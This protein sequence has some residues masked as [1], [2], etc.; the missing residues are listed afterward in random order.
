[1]RGLKKHLMLMLLLAVAMSLVSLP[2]ARAGFSDRETSRCGMGAGTWEPVPAAKICGLCPDWGL[3]GACRWPVFIYGK[4]FRE[5]AAAS[6]AKGGLSLP[7][8]KTW[9]LCSSAIYAVFDLRGAAEGAYDLR[10]DFSD[11]GKAVLYGG[12]RVVRWGNCSFNPTSSGADGG[13]SP[14][15]SQGGSGLGTEAWAKLTD[16]GSPGLLKLVAG[17]GSGAGITRAYAVAPGM[18]LEGA[19]A[20]NG[21]GRLEVRFDLRG[22][23]RMRYDVVFL[24]AENQPL[25]LEGFIT[26]ADILP[27][28]P[29]PAPAAQPGI[30]G[31]SGETS[32]A[33][34]AGRPPK[35]SQEGSV[36]PTETSLGEGG[37]DP[38]QGNLSGQK[39]PSGQPIPSQRQNPTGPENLSGQQAPP[40]H[41]IPSTQT[42]P[43]GDGDAGVESTAKGEAA[44]SEVK[45]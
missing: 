10:L 8:V 17:N 5:E 43:C 28:K 21:E 23:P 27:L 30:D 29:S 14:M 31:K 22:A 19:V 18:L 25:L 26:P 9:V 2:P 32:S 16:A 33:E 37:A 20:W 39:T 12:F 6:L 7:A 4:G 40:E 38:G 35:P 41:E 11:G 45:E 36:S 34:E 44:P 42:E 3:A 13:A 1:M 24:A 15:S